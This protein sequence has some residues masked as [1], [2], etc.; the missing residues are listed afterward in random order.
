MD[1]QFCL[2]IAVSRRKKERKFSLYKVWVERGAR[3]K[4]SCSK[5]GKG[6][7]ATLILGVD[8]TS[9]VKR[10]Y[11]RANSKHTDRMF[12]DVQILCTWLK[13]SCTQWHTLV[14][15]KVNSRWSKKTNEKHSPFAPRRRWNKNVYPSFVW[16]SFKAPPWKIIR[17]K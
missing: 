9:L 4:G 15:H 13:D 8:R 16:F 10:A 2:L 6:P 11:W 5:L 12:T 17:V 1:C 14:T 7:P 3:S